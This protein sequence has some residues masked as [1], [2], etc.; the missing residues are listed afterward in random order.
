MCFYVEYKNMNIITLG[1]DAE[2]FSYVV[3]S[4]ARKYNIYFL[5]VLQ[6]KK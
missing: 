3:L 4:I 6:Q 2:R 1:G 5:N